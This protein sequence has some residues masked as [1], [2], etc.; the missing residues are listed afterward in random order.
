MPWTLYRYFLKDVVR[1]LL[2]AAAVLVVLMS[3]GAAIKPLTDGLLGPQ[4][5]MRFLF[6]SAPTFLGFVLPFAGAFAATLVFSRLAGD[7]E[8]TACTASGISYASI[9][10]PIAALGLALTMGLFYLSNWVVPRFYA[11]TASVIEQ[12]ITRVIVTTIQKGQPVTLDDLSK[13]VLYADAA[14]EIE[15]EPVDEGQVQP[16]RQIVLNK[17]VFAQRD[18]EGQ[19]SGD[20]SAERAD[21][22]LY[23]QQAQSYAIVVLRN[24]AQYDAVRGQFD[25]RAA[26]IAEVA[27]P[28]VKLRS[29]LRDNPKFLSLPEIRKLYRE[30]E[31]FDRIRELKLDLARAIAGEQ[32]MQAIA[33][34]IEPESGE[35]GAAL[36]QG[37]RRAEQYRVTAPSARRTPNG[38]RLQGNPQQ[39]VRI[40][41]IYR[42]EVAR[43]LTS[44]SALITVEPGNIDQEPLI[45]TQMTEVKVTDPRI[46][47]PGTEHRQFELPRCRWPHRIAGSLLESASLDELG[48]A[49]SDPSLQR[50]GRDIRHVAFELNKERTKLTRRVVAQLHER[51][52]SA[53]A[54][55]LLLLLGAVLSMKLRTSQTLV[56]FFWSCIL[57]F[58]TVIII[59]AGRHMAEDTSFA[60]IIP[61]LSLLWSGNLL[62]AVVVGAAYCVLARN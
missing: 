6:Y 5:L 40:E 34:T 12:D 24:F 17:V 32:L 31:R 21:V 20:Y 59:N 18:E 7:N 47:G 58:V 62:L 13:S 23:H 38:L 3:F 33:A 30:P 46:G 56:V 51:A 39:P 11:A 55:P 49:A 53:I 28:P 57:A 43:I 10:F 27:L 35:P 29:P 16:T 26:Q 48:T 25:A 54:C 60:T 8:I 14:T 41:Y 61:G 45:V 50:G 2:L 42:G 37:P 36:L 52:A 19:V 9:L 44:T 22:F 4:G 15:P 1:V